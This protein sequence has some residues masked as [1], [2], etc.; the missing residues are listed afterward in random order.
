MVLRKSEGSAW[1]FIIRSHLLI[2]APINDTG[3]NCLLALTVI[4]TCS[5]FMPIVSLLRPSNDYELLSLLRY[6]FSVEKHF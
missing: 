3:E 6:S 4:Q 2:P 1:Y 5:H